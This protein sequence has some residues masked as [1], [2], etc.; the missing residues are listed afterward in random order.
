MEKTTAISLKHVFKFPASNETNNI[1][2]YKLS[3]WEETFLISA[4]LDKMFLF[5]AFIKNY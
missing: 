3:R 5:M 1:S 4:V 2:L